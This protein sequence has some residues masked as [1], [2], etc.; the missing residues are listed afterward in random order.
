MLYWEC[1]KKNLRI[2]TKKYEKTDPPEEILMKFRVKFGFAF[3]LSL[4]LGW[5]VSSAFGETVSLRSSGGSEAETGIES[6]AEKDGSGVRV[7][8]DSETGGILRLEFQGKTLVPEGDS[9]MPFDIS[10][11]EKETTNQKWIAWNDTEFLGLEQPDPQTV[12]LRYRTGGWTVSLTWFWDSGKKMLGRKVKLSWNGGEEIKIRAFWWRFPTFLCEDGAYFFTPGQFPPQKHTIAEMDGKRSAWDRPGIVQLAKDCSL[13]FIHDHADPMMDQGGTEFARKMIPYEAQTAAGTENSGEKTGEKTGV[14]VTQI[15]NIMGRIRP[16]DVQEL[17]TTYLAFFAG[18]GEAAL[19]SVHGC[20]ERLGRTVPKDRPEVFQK[21][22]LYSFHPGGS[23]G[24][25]MQDLGGFSA[26]VPFVDRIAET[27]LNSVWMLPLEDRGIY[28]PRDYY[29]FQDGL[30]T[31]EEYRALVKRMH[32][33]GFYVMQDCVPHGGSNEFERAKQ[34]PEWLVYD[35]DGSTFH[36]WCFDFN[37]PTWREYMKNVAKHYMK[38]Y[39]VDGYRIDAVSGSKIPNWNPEIP[40]ARASFAKLQAGFNMQRAIREG[41][42]EE[43]PVRGGVLA[44]VGN[45]FFGSVS[46]AVYDFAGCY[47]VF[48]SLRQDPPKEFVQN[49][50]RWFHEC[51]MGS[52][53][54]LLRMRHSESHD[55]LRSQY[56][57][58]VNAARAVV[59]LTAMAD[60]IPLI[61]QGQEV[62]NIET[63]ARLFAVRK[64]L[65]EMQNANFDYLGVTAPDGVWAVGYE[66]DGMRSVGFINFNDTPIDFELDVNALPGMERDAVKTVTEMLPGRRIA[67]QD[68]KVRVTL[69][70]YGAN[71]YAL[72]EVD[73][74]PPSI[75]A[76]ESAPE[77]AVPSE[78]VLM[79]SGTEWKAYVNGTTGL[80]TSMTQNGKELLGTAVF[81]QAADSPAVCISSDEKKLVFLKKYG[82]VE[83]RLTYR[84]ENDRLLLSAEWL[85]GPAPQDCTLYFPCPKA[86][87]WSAR[88]AEGI[89]R[90]RL[91]YR[92]D[93][94]IDV[95]ARHSIYWRPLEL[96]VLYDSFYQPL[97]R[98]ASVSAEWSDA[99]VSFCFDETQ[100]PARVRWLN[101]CEGRKVLTAAVSLNAPL[102]AELTNAWTVAIVPG[103]SSAGTPDLAASS[104]A[105]SAS[106]VPNT[107][108]TLRPTA[109]GYFFE[110]AH[111]SLTISRFGHVQ[112]FVSKKTGRTIFSEGVLYTDYGLG[113]KGERYLNS[114]EIETWARLDTLENGDV[115][116]HF[117]GRLRKKDRFGRMPQPV[118]FVTEFTLGDSDSLKMRSRID[119]PHAKNA[120]EAFLAWMLNSPT[121]DEFD[122]RKDG[123]TIV[124]ERPQELNARAWQ[125][126]NGD[127]MP[128]EMILKAVGVPLV[129]VTFTGSSH[130]LPANIFMDRKNFFLCFFD[131]KLNAPV[132]VSQDF[133]WTFQ[134]H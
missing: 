40:Y 91:F 85:N 3:L 80:L 74:V 107:N 73:F 86:G 95:N 6:A 7:D 116:L 133:E 129:T 10:Q 26:A 1:V 18:D 109:G 122:F 12:I 16:G 108:F 103:T 100:I 31:G 30:G 65:P 62:G 53:K 71:V 120:S 41:V 63:Y 49:V 11:G 52:M 81:S 60:G 79:L 76:F 21:L 89:L 98:E 8:F 51:Q 22:L 105:E 127:V 4:C 121:I 42:K 66:K 75:T 128:D 106:G 70:P 27:G 88:T 33:L 99:A 9:F 44:E 118:S 17:G 123:R 130:G 59:A 46:D 64:A 125:T 68:G 47:H 94:T 39:G 57:Y 117:E 20:F 72:R 96:D 45:D 37:W 69:P 84:A 58:G 23:I 32:E 119:A 102:N 113:P 36:Y 13:I 43:S 35:E 114:N 92:T 87:G 2:F 112:N 56:W 55:S 48:Q 134:I 61:Y 111:F 67:V 34:H 54:G 104:A 77:C 132:P 15:F 14:Q 97:W 19:N 25:N 38:N 29:R 24:S 78:N 90:D 82:P 93:K 28:W 126:K 131:G 115:R 83:C 110:N 50:R 101:R 124:S 5:M